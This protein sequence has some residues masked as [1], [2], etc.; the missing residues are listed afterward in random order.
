MED[1]P[2]EYS[3][4]LK[5]LKNPSVQEWYENREGLDL[6]SIQAKYKPRTTGE[7][8]VH[9][10]IIEWQ[11]EPVGYIQF[12]ETRQETDYNLKEPLLQE[13][14]TWAIDIF[15]GE[16]ELHGKGIG[17]RAVS[18][19]IEYLIQTQ[20]AQKVIIDPDVKNER[21]IK[22]YEKAGFKKLKILEN[23]EQHRGKWTDA[24]LMVYE[25]M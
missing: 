16:P 17:S 22:A 9:A 23:W 18:L 25:K 6:E 21:A 3:L 10:A 1:S 12:Y 13:A 5:W 7:S 15:I 19:M 20:K 24:W 11:K 14:N 4:L 2:E 8:H